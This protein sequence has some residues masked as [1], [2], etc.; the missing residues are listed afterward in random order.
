M[1]FTGRWSVPPLRSRRGAWERGESMLPHILD[2]QGKNEEWVGM[3]VGN[4]FETYSLI[5][6]LRKRTSPFRLKNPIR[7][8]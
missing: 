4:M 8:E 2:D 5:S 3:G 7:P 1:D 6:M